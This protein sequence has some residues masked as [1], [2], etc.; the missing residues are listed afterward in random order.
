[1]G[2]PSENGA[3]W[4]YVAKRIPPYFQSLVVTHNGGIAIGGLCQRNAARRVVVLEKNVTRAEVLRRR[5]ETVV[6]G[7]TP[8]L[9]DVDCAVL[10]PE[11]DR[12]WNTLEETMGEMAEFLSEYALFVVLVSPG[13]D[14]GTIEQSQQYSILDRWPFANTVNDPQ[15]KHLALLLTTKQYDRF[16]HAQA[17]AEANHPDWAV[18]LLALREGRDAQEEV[19]RLLAMHRY[20]LAWDD[21]DQAHERPSR[22]FLS[23]SF[24]A[25]IT[26]IQPRC[27]ETYALHAE[28]WTRLGD[29]AMGDRLMRSIEYAERA[30][31]SRPLPARTEA[32]ETTPAYNAEFKPRLL[33]ILEPFP[34]YGADVL[35]DG[36]AEVLGDDNVID[37]PWKPTLHGAEPE[38]QQNYPCMFD[39]PGVALAFEDVVEQLRAGRFDAVL[40]GVHTNILDGEQLKILT[41]ANANTPVYIIDQSDNSA[42]HRVGMAAHVGAPMDAPYF[43]REMLQCLD[44]G[45]NAFPLPFAYPIDRLKPIQTVRN[46]P[47][48]WAG[49]RRF[50]QRRLYLEHIESLLGQA[51]DQHLAQEA[52]A[53]QLS[54]ARIGLNL[55][56][57][58]YDTV[59]Y[60]ELPA[61]GAMLLA[62]RLPIRVPHNFVDGESAVFFDDLEELERRLMYYLKRPEGVARIAHAGRDHLEQFHTGTARAKQLLA[63]MQRLKMDST[64]G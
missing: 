48:F 33:M 52:Y 56:G 26:A 54:N 59:R 57:F 49:H 53:E 8:Q 40:Y 16:A 17:L 22:F 55:F 30:D 20:L 28:F 23:Q 58:G 29:A 2:D 61:H 41:A 19:E 62:E 21:R 46:V 1:M 7:P 60:W 3:L 24:I 47:L 63:H 51:F 32:K 42:N 18:D 34:D 25:K 13:R 35:F 64:T 6:A 11:S 44:Y 39:R 36:L 45:P 43:K 14:V 37:F 15:S 38:S 4:R 27:V 9:H 50:G 12:E 5:F 31:L 10:V